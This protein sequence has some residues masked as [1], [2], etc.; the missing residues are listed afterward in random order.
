MTESNVTFA[1]GEVRASATEGLPLFIVT[2][3]G[4]ACTDSPAAVEIASG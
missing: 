2:D 3:A 4:T 1:A